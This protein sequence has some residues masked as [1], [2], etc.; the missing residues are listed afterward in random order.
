[1]ARQAPDDPF[2]NLDHLATKHGNVKSPVN[3]HFHGK[4]GNI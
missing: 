2:K 4:Y 3:G 1:M